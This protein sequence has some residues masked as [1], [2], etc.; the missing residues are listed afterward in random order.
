[1]RL[2]QGNSKQSEP[3][4]D[5]TSFQGSEKWQLSTQDGPQFAAL[6]GDINFIHLHP[7]LARLFGFKSN[8]A[9]GVYLVS[10]SIAAMQ[11]GEAPNVILTPTLPCHALLDVTVLRN[12]TTV[13]M[14]KWKWWSNHA[15]LQ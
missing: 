8:I 9:H 12:A 3:E 4:L 2:L 5:V 7:I 1:M 13:F 14:H 6:N 10:K 11:K 15:L